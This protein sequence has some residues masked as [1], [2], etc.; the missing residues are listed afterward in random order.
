LEFLVALGDAMVESGDPVAHIQVSLRRI[1]EA[2]GAHDAEIIVLP[3]ALII[4]LSGVARAETAVSTTGQSSLRLDQI[5]AVFRVLR[6]A[7]QGEIDPREG[8]ARLRQ[9]RTMP[10]PFGPV[11]SVVG[12]LVLTAGLAVILDG[13]WPD[14]VLAGALGS[15]VGVMRLW[16]DRFRPALR[17]VLPVASAFVVSATVFLLAR[18]GLH[19]NLLAPL[20]AP[21]ITFLPGALLTTAVIELATGQMMSGSGRLVSG[22][23]QLVLL[24]FGIVAG[25]QLV[26]V[27]ELSVGAEPAAAPLGPIAPWI[28]VLAFGVGVLLS[29]AGPAS[30]LGWM[31]LVLYVA[32]AGQVIGGLLFGGLVSGFFG[33][34][35]MTPVATFA[36]TQRTGPPTM[37]TFLPGFWLLAPGA[38]SLAGVAQILGQARAD[39]FTAVFGAGATFVAIA[40]GVVLGQLV[41]DRIAARGV[42]ADRTGEVRS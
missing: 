32:H 42:S 22:G 12:Q 34:L 3:T 37:V 38:I 30:A 8:W 17:V 21:L 40:L 28:G 20:I 11:V 27:P 4:S 15:V 24:A 26:G 33:A 9:A 2:N 36:A 39:G 41:A 31:L 1:A 5:D 6:A 13:G 14:L 23:V 10:P 29:Y 16:V 7:E 35:L 18:G 25:A 19:T